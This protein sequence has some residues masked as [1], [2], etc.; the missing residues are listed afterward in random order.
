MATTQKL[1]ELPAIQYTGMDYVSVLDQIQE[2]IQAHPNWKKNWTEFYNSEAGVLLTQLMSWICD[3]LGVRQ[4]L[5][6]NENFLATATSTKAKIRLLNQI[7]YVQKS[8][9]AAIVPI[10][11]EYND[12]LEN[13]A[14]I[15]CYQE[16]GI[17]IAK[18][19]DSIHSFSG[20][21]INGGP[22]N[23]EILPVNTDGKIDYLKPLRIPAGSLTYDKDADGNQLVAIQGKTV[24]REFSSDVSDGPIF[25]L[26][27]DGIDISSLVIFD[28]TNNNLLH[29]RVDTFTDYSV[30]NDTST[31]KY[32]IEKNDDGK[33]QI[34][35]PSE[36]FVTF[37]NSALTDRMF[38]A[39]N[40]IGVIYR[41]CN[42]S[43]GNIAANYLSIS[44]TIDGQ[45]VTISN[46]MAGYNGRDEETLSEAVISGPL[47]ITTMNRAVTITDFNRIL[48]NNTLIK[49][50]ISFSP[51]NE[52]ENFKSYYGRR[53][54]P[55]EIF[56]FAVLNKN[57]NNCPASKL[58]YFPW[59]ELNKESI[60]NEKYSFGDGEFNKL[61][62]SEKQ[63]YKNLYINDGR[64]EFPGASYF[65]YEN[66][67]NED[68]GQWY[69]P[70]FN[71]KKYNEES[72]KLEKDLTGR[73]IRNAKILRTSSTIQDAIE[74]DLSNETDNFE[75]KLHVN[76]TGDKYLK[77]IDIDFISN[78]GFSFT[79]RGNVL[80]DETVHAKYVSTLVMGVSEVLDCSNYK[81]IK[82][83][84]DDNLEVVV[85]IQKEKK[86][87]SDAVTAA[88]GVHIE[89]YSH[90]LLIDNEA[91]TN[92][93]EKAAAFVASIA[94][95]SVADKT[96]KTSDYINSDSSAMFKSGIK[97]LINQAIRDAANYNNELATEDDTEEQEKMYRAA[98]ASGQLTY[99]DLGRQEKDPDE[100]N[101]C[102]CEY[103]YSATN[104]AKTFYAPDQFGKFYRIKINDDIY[105]VRL[106]RYTYEAAY[107][108]F[109]DNKLLKDI[110]E[111][112]E[113]SIYYDWHPYIGRGVVKDI[114]GE[115]YRAKAL[116][117]DGG[118][119]GTYTEL[120]ERVSAI[121]QNFNRQLVSSF[122]IDPALNYTDEEDG[123]KTIYKRINDQQ[124]EDN[125][126]CE[127]TL[128]QLATTLEYLFS[129]FNTR[130]KTVYKYVDGVWYD[131]KNPEDRSKL[132]YEFDDE[133]YVLGGTVRTRV[134]R[135][136][137]NNYNYA[138]ALDKGESSNTFDKYEYD[139]RIERI[140]NAD[141][142]FDVSSVSEAEIT[143]ESAPAK[144][145]FA[146]DFYLDT[147]DF[148]QEVLGYRKSYVGQNVDYSNEA[149]NV[150]TIIGSTSYNLVIQSYKTGEQSTLYF[151]QSVYDK[152]DELIYKLGLKDGFYR[153]LLTEDELL[154]EEDH[155]D[156]VYDRAVSLKSFGRK[157]VELYVN[158]ASTDVEAFINPRDEDIKE[159]DEDYEYDPGMQ[160]K[161]LLNVGDFIFE[162][163]DIN[164]STLES[165]YLSYV[166][167]RNNTQ[168]TL[169]KYDNFYY[170]DDEETNERAK[171]AIVGIEGESVKEV[172]GVYYIDD[173]KSNY[174]VKITGD[175]VDTNN[176]YAIPDTEYDDLGIIKNDRVTLE[177]RNMEGYDVNSQGFN[178]LYYGFGEL[179]ERTKA[180]MREAV[181]LQLPILISIDNDEELPIDTELKDV[182]MENIVGEIIYNNPVKTV[183]QTTGTALY[184]GLIRA[185]KASGI[186]KFDG[187]ENVAIKKSIGGDNKLIFSSLDRNEGKITFYYPESFIFGGGEDNDEAVVATGVNMLYKSMFG[188]N[189]T[190]PDFYDLYP[191][192][193]MADGIINSPSVVHTIN[194]E[195][196]EYFYAP[197]KTNR[198]KFVYRGFVETSE[199]RESK[200]GDY[201]I[202]A[203]S[204]TGFSG[205]GYKFYLHKTASSVFPDI[206]FY[207]HFVNDRTF[208]YKR[209]SGEYKTE[210]DRLVDY[211]NKYKILGTDMY[212]LKPYFKTFDIIAKVNYDAN[213]DL[214]IVKENVNNALAKYKIENIETFE[215]GNTIYRSDIFK[216]LIE[217]KGVESAE[218]DYFGYDAT[219]E[220]SDQ[221]FFLENDDN[222]DFCAINVLADT[223]DK[224]GL[225]LSYVKVNNGSFKF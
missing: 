156:E 182:G 128:N 167:N 59:V 46:V 38:V 198:L 22:V 220:E 3:N 12:I 9:S 76:Q 4:D 33:W 178:G 91:P 78:D 205:D 213:Y 210:E 184:T 75:C 172:E 185:M 125:I 53:I 192:E 161:V 174:G 107:D 142:R 54:N 42:G 89:P 24:Y 82:L 65:N 123:N 17:E 179:T 133:G 28:I 164:F 183:A 140:G 14:Y 127:F 20:M 199:G 175:V 86:V 21:D 168:L 193:A 58:N 208:E 149:S 27:E 214:S 113:A 43:D 122:V 216:A 101:Y 5:I 115:D 114:A 109:Y 159:I 223:T 150:A 19:V 218:I 99:I 34:R 225:I 37:N 97:Q 130:E 81:Y 177:C 13:D 36:S 71:Y 116:E 11:I 165:V 162:D 139:L 110:A 29:E 195:T 48:K 120:I 169:D 105:A 202:T 222:S 23:Y 102:K 50:C 197:T 1:T 180:L 41:T 55:Q 203:V 136:I 190:N 18:I 224:H 155:I 134:V 100:T 84:L 215:I 124:Q 119:E 87:L 80:L 158:G 112:S 189:V 92:I 171:P 211:M 66:Y 187:S 63:I 135:R 173:N 194:E 108:D 90:Y 85:D 70:R 201:Y 153:D 94:D 93:D 196:G 64:E 47:A 83:V 143:T 95:L 69:F 163:N 72:G 118:T 26:P 166:K 146:E 16:D 62:K 221:K 74:A 157:R 152:D 67:G 137:N 144:I 138:M 79:T 212:L 40:K 8:A 170:S 44:D 209:T 206:P 56:S 52:P 15:S 104:N 2:I 7:E 141:T 68:G 126:S 77:N 131:T 96:T 181:E 132:G 200:F 45:S 57:I 88:G 61:V 191:K 176:Y 160:E 147:Y 117:L 49:N 217:A 121:N 31:I 30:L 154:V 10:E 204:E 188:T 186:E 145:E 6:Y 207:V 129:V 60:L 219:D 25:A 98:E 148:I 32:I 103:E 151:V 51:D 35:Y 39:G 111:I 73:L 106:D